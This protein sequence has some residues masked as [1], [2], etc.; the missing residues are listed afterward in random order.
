LKLTIIIKIKVKF[1]TAVNEMTNTV[2][3]FEFIKISKQTIL[4]NNNWY[5]RLKV[6]NR[7]QA[8]TLVCDK[9]TTSY[10]SLKFV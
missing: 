4:G 3:G 1:A 6:L 10:M 2:I 7:K 8:S 9:Q 5:Y